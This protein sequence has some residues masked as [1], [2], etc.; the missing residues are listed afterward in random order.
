MDHAVH[1]DG[2]EPH[3][4]APDI[5]RDAGPALRREV[6]LPGGR[7]LVVRHSGLDDVVGLTALYET[8][9]VDDLRYRFFAVYHPDRAFHERQA[10]MDRHG[11]CGLVAVLEPA[12]RIVAQAS[13]VPLDDG[14]GELAL[15]VAP[16]WRG[17]VGPYLLDALAEVAAA[18][19]VPNL[20]ADVLADNRPMLAL[21]RRRGAVWMANGDYA[22]VRA[23]IATDA[24]LPRWEARRGAPL[25][26]VE[27]PSGRWAAERSALAAHWRVVGCG[28]S[29]ANGR[30]ACP[31]RTGRVCPL[32]AGADV[33]VV[34]APDGRRSDLPARHHHLHPGVR[35][36]VDPGD[37]ARCW[38]EVAG[39]TGP[40]NVP[41]R[42]R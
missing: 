41:R 30:T 7:H 36:V 19:G 26:V 18:R 31:A 40:A 10:G 39:R 22:V 24:E 17:W 34:I 1:R 28:R 42:P 25:L 33:V 29:A 4:T 6:A 14:G 2:S 3:D 21:L 5:G 16:D 35:V 9:S 13:Y 15:A 37:A 38:S 27:S 11:G 12:G 23:A 20:Q 32:A 8:L